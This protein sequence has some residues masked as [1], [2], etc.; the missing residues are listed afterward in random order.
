MGGEELGGPESDRRLG[1]VSQW[2]T[3]LTDHIK[4]A[5]GLLAVLATALY[6]VAFSRFY[7]ALDTSPE[8]VGITAT[9]ML[10][11]SAVGGIVFLLIGSLVVLAPFAP[12][13]PLISGSYVKE[14]RSNGTI[15]DV[16]AIGFLSAV[17]LFFFL[18]AVGVPL[19]PRL[20]IALS[21][22]L[23]ALMFS[24]E[25]ERNPR[26]RIK[27]RKLR[28][29][30][31]DFAVA[32][33]LTAAIGLIAFTQKTIVTADDL[34]EEARA[35]EKIDS[36][37]FLGLPILG[38]SADPALIE[39]KGVDSSQFDLPACVL[40]LGQS[41][42]TTVVY[43]AVHLQ[44]VQLPA[45]AT[46]LSVQHSRTSCA[47]P[48]NLVEPRV[49]REGRYLKCLPGKWQQRPPA[50]LEYGWAQD[51]YGV[52]TKIENKFLLGPG[53]LGHSIRCGVAASSVLGTDVA[54]SEPL[55]PR[56]R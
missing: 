15:E 54:Y 53:N 19:V 47:A 23:L 1:G 42:G 17:V 10:A 46:T 4:A 51:G 38:L 37:S 8:A 16:A 33:L 21:P 31:M 26:M 48:M 28:V 9:D 39:M 7:E 30:N 41:D 44:T 18:L 50:S 11:R 20:L 5:L 14:P 35:G 36:P 27:A 6:G 55:V 2:V 45:E 12:F 13:I 3:R 43:D 56:A 29:R 24:V 49:R 52:I 22:G 32:A 25:V 40:Y 34:G